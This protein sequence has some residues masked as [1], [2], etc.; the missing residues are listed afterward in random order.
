[1][2]FAGQVRRWMAPVFSVERGSQHT[3]ASLPEN[4][5]NAVEG[6]LYVYCAVIRIQ[7]AIY[8]DLP[9]QQ[10]AGHCRL[11]VWAFRHWNHASDRHRHPFAG[12]PVDNVASIVAQRL[13]CGNII[14]LFWKPFR[15]HLKK[16]CHVVSY[17]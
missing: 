17:L 10:P 7:T 5:S 11:Q 14:Y 8:G 13:P 2:C 12:L 1:M 3:R 4:Q 15:H 16:E 6:V 9:P